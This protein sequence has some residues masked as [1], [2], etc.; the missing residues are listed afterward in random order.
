MAVDGGSSSKVAAAIIIILP[1]Y[2]TIIAH[3]PLLVKLFA[4]FLAD[5]EQR[6][7]S[8]VCVVNRLS[9]VNMLSSPRI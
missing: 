2:N 9:K 3:F 5:A 7:L 4:H 8:L 1:H 6:G